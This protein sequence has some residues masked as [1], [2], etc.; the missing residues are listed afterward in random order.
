MSSEDTIEGRLSV[1]DDLLQRSLE[2]DDDN[3]ITCLVARDGLLDALL[4]LYD[5]CCHTKLMS[6]KHV[7]TFVNKCKN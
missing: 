7:A 3:I 1:L 6:N 2:C 5:E 4:A